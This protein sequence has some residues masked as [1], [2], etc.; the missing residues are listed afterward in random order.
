MKKPIRVPLDPADF[1]ISF[2]D[3]ASGV[4]FSEVKAPAD[5]VYD[6][7]HAIVDSN[8]LRSLNAYPGLFKRLAWILGPGVTLHVHVGQFAYEQL[9]SNRD[10][11]LGKLKD[12]T[13]HPALSDFFLPGFAASFI[14]ALKAAESDMRVLIGIQAVYLFTIRSLF[15]RKKTTEDTIEC[16]RELIRGNVTRLS[17]L[18]FMGILFLRGKANSRLAFTDSNIKIQDWANHFLA[19]RKEEVGDPGRWARNRAFDFMLFSNAPAL[20]MSPEGGMHG[21]LITVTNDSYAAQCLYRLFAYHGEQQMD[22]AWNA[23]FNLSCLKKVED[24]IFELV[25]EES[26]WIHDA[27][28]NSEKPSADE[29][30]S[31][32]KNLIDASL[33]LLTEEHKGDLMR[34]LYEFKVFSWM[35]ADSEKE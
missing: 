12:L 31:R 5:G 25:S 17:S 23:I 19:V 6:T 24:P 20:N 9:L 34:V 35:E 28:A 13:E 7:V 29:R 32:V 16:L 3:V 30:K 4:Y 22:T 11:A 21:R 2:K 10:S 33:K 14:S 18:Y 26:R 15:E 8:I 27:S 1:P